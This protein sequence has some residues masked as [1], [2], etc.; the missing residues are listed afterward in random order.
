MNAITLPKI[1]VG[2][3]SRQIQ[4]FALL[5]ELWRCKRLILSCMLLS[6]LLGSLYAFFAPEHY[7]VQS[8]L[9]PASIGN[10]DQLNQSGIYKLSPQEAM[11]RVGAA[12][13]SY[14]IRL[15]FYKSHAALF[16]VKDQGAFSERV[17]D[18]FNKN[19]SML[20]PDTRERA[21]TAP[22]IGVQFTYPEK[23]IDGV[24]VVNQFVAY[25]IYA[26]NRQIIADLKVFIANRL[27]QLQQKIEAARVSYET[28]KESQIAQLQESDIL[29]LAKLEDER[30]SLRNEAKIRRLSRI[31]QLDEAIE[32]ARRLGLSKPA[33]P[34]SL[35][36]SPQAKQS[37]ISNQISNQQLPLYFMGTEAL[38]AERHVL[39]NR[40]SD[41]FTE[42][43][44]LKLNGELERLKHNRQIE[45][46][47]D[48]Q[49]EDLFL[50]ELAAWRAEAARLSSFNTENG[51]SRLVSIDQPAISPLQSSNPGIAV[52]LLGS[53]FLG[54][55]TGVG[56]AI[57]CI[58]R[59][60]STHPG[61]LQEE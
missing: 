53:L 22:F 29:K 52:M 30:N 6:G 61:R 18:R 39:I 57:I 7:V 2:R 44:I 38:A 60:W 26:V 33:T 3:S 31:K 13:D 34:S 17:F 1:L 9:R 51:V 10:L 58:L 46:L 48:R 43:R 50:D 40:V 24:A 14:D 41:D 54:V 8:I 56:V 4:T 59:R 23:T 55:M 36:H 5:R 12:L 21:T 35:S 37:L 16:G 49:H 25:A 47:R 11:Q 32:I 42:P 27:A 20:W 28:S 45:I 15:G 19:L